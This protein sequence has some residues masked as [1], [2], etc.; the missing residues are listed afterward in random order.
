MRCEIIQKEKS[1][2]ATLCRLNFT[3]SPSPASTD[4]DAPSAVVGD[5][6]RLVRVLALAVRR[7]REP[8]AILRVVA[9]LAGVGGHAKG[10]FAADRHLIAPNTLAGDKDRHQ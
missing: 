10:G 5:A 1:P 6:H 9:T 4:Q 8:T 7:Q 2:V 3:S